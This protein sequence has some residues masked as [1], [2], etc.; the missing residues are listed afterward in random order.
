MIPDAFAARDAYPG[1][2][3]PVVIIAGE[4]DRLIDIDRQSARIHDDIP[5]SVL[6]RMPGTGHMIHQTATDSV[7][8]AINEAASQAR[9]TP[10][11][12]VGSASGS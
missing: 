2:E 6:H 4:E 7:M 3:M 12:D 5:H 9:G 11:T 10:A 1:L 8:S